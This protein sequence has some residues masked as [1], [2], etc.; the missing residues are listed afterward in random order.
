MR[1]KRRLLVVVMTVFGAGGLLAE[2]YTVSV[3]EG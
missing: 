1:I 2:D 3:P